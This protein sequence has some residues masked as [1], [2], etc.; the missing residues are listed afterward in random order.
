MQLFQN[1]VL[2]QYLSSFHKDDI[3]KA[4]EIYKSD[5]LPK[6]ENIKTMKEEQY[7]SGFL[8]DIFVDILG[9]TLSPNENYNLTTEQKNLTDSKKA[10]GAI[11][12]DGKVIAVIELKS[13]KTKSMDSI[14]NQAFN[15]KN[16]HPTCKYI[17]TSNFEKLRFYVEHSDKHEEFN[18]F[19]LNLESFTLLYALL[20]QK[21]IFSDVPLMLKQNS[22]LQEENISNELYKKYAGLRVNLFENITIPQ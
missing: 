17:I 6:I 2:K 18:L 4:F 11:L 10:D 15:Y 7:Q 14:V 21:S 22:K 1:S 12:K 20:S 8:N 16:N 3:L 13:T 19:K 9:Y 5:F